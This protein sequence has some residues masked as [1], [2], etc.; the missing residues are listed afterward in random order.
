MTYARRW[1]ASELLYRGEVCNAIVGGIYSL[2][3][4]CNHR[5]VDDNETRKEISDMAKDIYIPCP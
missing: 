3:M 4:Y 2:G 5:N 1:M